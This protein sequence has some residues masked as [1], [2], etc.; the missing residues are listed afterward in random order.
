V[1]LHDLRRAKSDER[2][3]P[4]YENNEIIHLPDDWEEIEINRENNI[5]Q[6]QEQGHFGQCT[7][8]PV[9]Q[10][11]TKQLQKTRYVAQQG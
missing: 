4:H 2:S 10:K 7:H 6:R 5:R 11:P 8:T 9:H 3:A 1:L